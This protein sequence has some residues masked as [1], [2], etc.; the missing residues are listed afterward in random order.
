MTGVR[1]LLGVLVL[2]GTSAQAGELQPHETLRETAAEFLAGQTSDGAIPPR[3]EVSRPDPRLRL[4]K[5]EL[6]LEAVLPRGARIAGNLA[7][8]VRCSG[9]RPW[10]VYL[11]ASVRVF[12]EVVVVT[13]PVPRGEPLSSDDLRV[14]IRDTTTLHGGY[15]TDPARVV[16]ML[17]RRSLAARAV[18]SEASIEEPTLVERGQQ[19]VV[20]ARAGGLEVRGGGK[21][22]SDG[23]HGELIRVRN[24]RSARVIEAMVMAPGTVVVQF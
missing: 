17:V 5:C 1:W 21:A 6:P 14:E 13:R 2:L 3:I 16:G 4:A 8:G 15:L 11:T 18:A 20:V 10:T 7:I 19:V 22:L 24:D 9:A 23:R 12:R